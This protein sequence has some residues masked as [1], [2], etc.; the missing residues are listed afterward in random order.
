MR[1]V[2]V[3]RAAHEAISDAWSG[4]R[5]RDYAS[6]VQ[7]IC[8]RSIEDVEFLV[9][10]RCTHII[11]TDGEGGFHT[12]MVPDMFGMATGVRVNLK[13]DRGDSFAK[14]FESRQFFTICQNFPDDRPFLNK[15]AGHEIRALV[16][17]A[18][19]YLDAASRPETYNLTLLGD[20]L[21]VIRTLH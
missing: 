3:T 11:E 6:A 18:A 7:R 1:T 16:K 9:E 20:V 21:D 5:K 19:A 2:K 13:H 8:A 14:A 17:L 12:R 15:L 10:G 4:P